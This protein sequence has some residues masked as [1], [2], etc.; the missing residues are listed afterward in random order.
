MFHVSKSYSSKNW[1]SV[2]ALV[3]VQ[4]ALL[5]APQNL[6]AQTTEATSSTAASGENAGSGSPAE[7]LPARG[8][9]SSAVAL[10]DAAN[11]VTDGETA[12]PET[13]TPGTGEAIGPGGLLGQF[14]S[15]PL[16]LILLSAILFMFIVVRPQQRKYKDL[17]KALADLKK[18]D[19]VVTAS[20]IHGTVVQISPESNTISIRIDENSGA[21]MT[22]N[23][24]AVATIVEP[25]SNKKQGS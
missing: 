21:R 8:T 4:L 15:N 9:D 13:A 22:V 14:F 24:D 6:L 7:G 17:Q 2:V 5:I 18:N 23:R 10:D 12:A 25:E 19:R 20:G 3:L 1:Q 16:N 11:P